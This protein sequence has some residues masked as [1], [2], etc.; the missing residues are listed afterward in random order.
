MRPI[1][2]ADCSTR[3]R[4]VRPSVDPWLETA[5]NVAIYGNEAGAYD[6]LLAYLKRRR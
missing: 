1:T 2:Q 6:E 3:A 4:N 5:R